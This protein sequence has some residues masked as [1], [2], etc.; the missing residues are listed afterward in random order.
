M[1]CDQTVGHLGAGHLLDLEGLIMQRVLECCSY[2]LI[3]LLLRVGR[4]SRDVFATSELDHL[5]LTAL[6]VCS[7]TII[8]L[9]TLQSIRKDQLVLPHC[10]RCLALQPQERS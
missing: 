3:L 6:R 4:E 8:S 5:F 10:R 1:L 2:F 9:L 7:N